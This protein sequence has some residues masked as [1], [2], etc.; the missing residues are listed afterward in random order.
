MTLQT[1]PYRMGDVVRLTKDRIAQK[2]GLEMVVYYG[3]I[4][5]GR[6]QYSTTSGAWYDHSG[7]ELVREADEASL[8]QLLRVVADEE[9][10]GVEYGDEDEADAATK[11][12][13]E[14]DVAALF[15]ASPFDDS[16][17]D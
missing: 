10:D 7:L 4:N 6:L 17:E 1:K 2:A 13:D 11:P 5:S 3:Q 8:L 12:P 14:T 15:T 16:D 9:D